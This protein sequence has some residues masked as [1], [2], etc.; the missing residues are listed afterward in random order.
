MRS[1]NFSCIVVLNFLVYIQLRFFNV[2]KFSLTFSF[3]LTTS[4]PNNFLVQRQNSHLLIYWKE[5]FFYP[6]ASN[7]ETY[8]A[9]LTQIHLPSGHVAS[10]K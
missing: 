5:S 6:L 9:M 10:I 7:R 8:D 3:L 4:I 2:K 1:Y